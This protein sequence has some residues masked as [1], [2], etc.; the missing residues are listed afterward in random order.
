M[1]RR[2][3]LSKIGKEKRKSGLCRL[4]RSRRRAGGDSERESQNERQQ[5][6]E[7]STD[8]ASGCQTGSGSKEKLPQVGQVPAGAMNRSVRAPSTSS[9]RRPRVGQVLS[10]PGSIFCQPRTMRRSRFVLAARAAYTCSDRHAIRESTG[11][12]HA[13]LDLELRP[14]R[15]QRA[16]RFLTASRATC[17]K[18]ANP[19]SSGVSRSRSRI[20]AAWVVFNAA[21]SPHRQRHAKLSKKATP[22]PKPAEM[23]KDWV[24]IRYDDK[25]EPLAM[26]SAIVRYEPAVRDPQAAG[27]PVTVD[28]VRRGPHRRR[29]LLRR[30]QSPL[31]SATTPCSTNWSRRKARSSSAAAAPRTRIRSARCRTA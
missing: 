19:R 30:A 24:R 23:G 21:R 16:A 28:L 4:C 6:L 27:P 26:E 11:D 2:Y 15:S 18:L 17:R 14:P 3:Q 31:R 25:H 5:G 29:R 12:R 13:S 20:V 22:P 8:V 1:R 7:R 10:I 9:Y